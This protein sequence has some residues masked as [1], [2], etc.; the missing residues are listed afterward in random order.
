MDSPSQQNTAGAIFSGAF[1]YLHQHGIHLGHIQDGRDF[2]IDPVEVQGHAGLFVVDDLF[3]QGLAQARDLAAELLK[4]SGL[5]V[6]PI[7]V[8]EC[9]MR[10][11]DVALAAV[12]G[13]EDEGLL[14]PKAFVVLR[15]SASHERLDEVR[16]GLQAYVKATLAKHKYP[17]WI[18][19]VDELP[20]NDRG[21]VDKKALREAERAKGAR[22]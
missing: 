20:K 22:C 13:A 18:E 1:P 5:W 7:E 14:K 10:H 11:Q 19:F 16:A 4:V 3:G 12:I 15:D 2:I 21:K 8:E 17:R 9:L 6:S